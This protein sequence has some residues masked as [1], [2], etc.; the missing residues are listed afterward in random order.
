MMLRTWLAA[1][2]LGAWTLGCDGTID[3]TIETPPNALTF[4]FRDTDIQLPEELRSGADVASVPCSETLVCPPPLGDQTFSCVDAVCDPDPIEVVLPVGDVIDF[5]QLNS[6]LRDVV[7]SI[8]AIHV[9]FVRYNV[10]QN[11]LNMT[12]DPVELAWGPA[13]A[14][15]LYSAGVR[16][17]GRIVQWPLGVNNV[18]LDEAGVDALSDYLVRTSRQI[19]IFARTQVDL[20]P[21]QRLPLGALVADLQLSIT[22]TGRVL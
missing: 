6:Q 8:E 19:R 3:I 7:G 17:L 10:T 21:G 18:D 2:W 11:D 14:T 16:P 5:E 9:D 15:D 13:Q 20:E 1:M 4:E 22:V 12:L